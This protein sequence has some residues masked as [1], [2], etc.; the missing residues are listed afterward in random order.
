MIMARVAQVEARRILTS[1]AR[2]KNSPGGIMNILHL[3]TYKPI[4]IYKFGSKKMMG[5]AI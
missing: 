2:V 5:A 3:Q 4:L 1:S